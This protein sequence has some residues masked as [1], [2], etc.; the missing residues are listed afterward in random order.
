M[1]LGLATGAP[2]LGQCEAVWPR[3]SIKGASYTVA[4]LRIAGVAS[5]IGAMIALIATA[6][7][8][9]PGVR[10]FRPAGSNRPILKINLGN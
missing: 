9:K 10:F 1:P 6:M 7:N 8:R 5:Y 3:G 4:L 2:G